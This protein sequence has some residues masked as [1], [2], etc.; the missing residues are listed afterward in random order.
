MQV[1]SAHGYDTSRA[2]EEW[3]PLGA[4]P[5]KRLPACNAVGCVLWRPTENAMES[6]QVDQHRWFPQARVRRCALTYGNSSTLYSVPTSP[7]SA[8]TN[9]DSMCGK[10]R[11]HCIDEPPPSP[12][13]EE[14][15]GLG[16][17]WA[18]N[19]VLTAV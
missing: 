11:K 13:S 4:G 2:A 1:V 7:V 14:V 16:F 10:Q 9:Q 18:V 6:R 8:E 3:T 17:W 12:L 15:G 5:V 19:F